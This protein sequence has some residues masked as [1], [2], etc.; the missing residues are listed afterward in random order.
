MPER[1]SLAT[2]VIPIVGESSKELFF[3]VLVE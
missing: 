2:V 1:Q 3:A